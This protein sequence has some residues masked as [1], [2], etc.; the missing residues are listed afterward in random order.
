MSPSIR[1]GNFLFNHVFFLYRPLYA[2]FKRRQDRFE[3]ALLKKYIHEG[4]V[5]LDIG[6]N[7]GFYATI[8]SRLVGSQGMVH[9]FEP[10]EV[11]FKYLEK[12]VRGKKNIK[13]Y[14]AAVAASTGEIKLYLSDELNVDHRTYAPAQYKSTKI[15]PCIA[16]DQIFSSSGISFV[17]MDIQGFETEAVKG[18]KGLLQANKNLRI[19]SEFWPYGLRQ[20]GSSCS[21]Y[22]NMLN[23]LGYKCYLLVGDELVELN[24][25]KAMKMENE[26]K[27]KYYNILA[28]R[29]D[30]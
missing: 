13:I 26:P 10:D 15:I 16:P 7:I 18:M 8:L 3:I 12:E 30:V 20:S 17:K 21:I 4:D 25:E 22:L 2:I 6:A 23:E 5:V 29:S 1:I 11:N 27:E 19:I 24:A 9:C 28:T 14:N